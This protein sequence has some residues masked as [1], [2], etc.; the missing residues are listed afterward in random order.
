MQ[1]PGSSIDIVSFQKTSGPRQVD[2]AQQLRDA[3]LP[4]LDE[5]YTLARYLM[6]D[7]ADAEDAVWE[8]Y[9]RARQ[10]FEREPGLAAKLW[11][12][13][14]LRNVCYEEL[15][16]RKTRE[17]APDFTEEDMDAAL[18]RSVQL[19]PDA[20]QQDRQATLQR[21]VTELPIVFREVIVLLEFSHLTYQEIADVTDAPAATVTLRVTRARMML[22]AARN[23]WDSA[24]YDRR[25]PAIAV[26]KR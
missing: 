1:N 6:G 9:V 4:Y 8:C 26:E 14:I 17:T 11:L 19:S 20:P 22:R 13:R 18:R 15:D 16:K 2:R 25:T 5:V 3:T 21:L 24:R 12:L 7:P 10:R 23:A